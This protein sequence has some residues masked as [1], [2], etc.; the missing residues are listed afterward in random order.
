MQAWLA[1][2]QDLK[3]SCDHL[4]LHL[5]RDYT[6]AHDLISPLTSYLI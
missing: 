3:E 2:S 5:A 6:C 1:S 4:N